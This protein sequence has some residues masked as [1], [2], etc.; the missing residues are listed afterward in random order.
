MPAQQRVWCRDCSD[1]P[2]GCPAHAVSPHGQA[3]AILVGQTQPTT[4]KLPAQE[5]VLFDQI[6]D[7]LPLPAVQAAGQHQEHHL[8]RRGVDHKAELIS[9]A[10][11]SDVGRVVEHY[12]IASKREDWSSDV[13]P[14][15]TAA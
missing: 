14:L 1:F 3:P 2:Q 6:G 13:S 9:R 8:E 15:K 7:R 4:P 10:G 12:G 5:P 11:L